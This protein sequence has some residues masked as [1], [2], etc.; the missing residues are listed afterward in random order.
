MMIRTYFS[1]ILTAILLITGLAGGCEQPTEPPEPEEPYF[2][3]GQYG[4]DPLEDTEHLYNLQLSPDGSKIALI[5]SRTPGGVFEPRDQLWIVNA[6]GTE[7]ELIGYN[8]GT[9]DWS[10]DGKKMAVT[11][12]P[13]AP[14]TY[15]FTISLDSMKATQWTG[16]EDMFLS[17]RSASNPRWFNDNQRLLI[18]VW[19]KAYKQPYERGVYIINTND[20]AIEGPLVEI[21]AGAFLGN[22]EKYFISNKYTTQ[23]NPLSGNYIRYDFLSNK[24]D[25]ITNTSSDSLNRW[26]KQ[27][28][29]NPKGAELVYTRHTKNAWQLFMMDE[30]GTN[31]EQLTELGGSEVSW[32]KDGRQVYFNRD[33]HKSPGARY[34]P[35]YYE[36]ATG[37]IAPIWP[38][39]PDSVPEFPALDTQNPI[40]FRGIVQD[41]AATS[42]TN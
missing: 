1:T 24:F 13:G 38:N 8:I 6:D 36:L 15:S 29:P 11:Y 35:H 3:P 17:K 20:Q 14:Y 34:I 39:L 7:P 41:S 42:N 2:K 31:E 5:R 30:K 12:I 9:V 10:I 21:A 16:S 18:S 27:P 19:A 32:S 33:T 23:D 40:D 25:W 4:G 37:N 26:V 28:R 22:N